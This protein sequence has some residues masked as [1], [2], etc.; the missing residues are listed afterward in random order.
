MMI[1]YEN[2]MALLDC[3]KIKEE[4]KLSESY[5]YSYGGTEFPFIAFLK[6]PYLYYLKIFNGYVNLIS[7]CARVSVEYGST[8]SS[9]RY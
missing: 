9:W 5:G 6:N 8:K 3:H 7:I 1:K 4:T 2:N